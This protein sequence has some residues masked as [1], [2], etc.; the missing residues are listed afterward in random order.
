MEADRAE[1][2]GTRAPP[3]INIADDGDSPSPDAAGG[4]DPA[5]SL[6]SKR[7][8]SATSKVWDDFDALYEVKNGKRVRT[9]AKCK[10]FS[11]LYSGKSA[12][13][14]GH[15]HRHLPKCPT[16]LQQSR[17]A[18]SLYALV[19]LMLLRSIF[20]LLIILALPLCQGK[21]PLEILLS[22]LMSV[23]VSLWPFFNL[24]HLL[25]LPLTPGL[26]MLRK[27]TLVWLLIML[28]LIGN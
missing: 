21:P 12:S 14:T 24:L 13:C 25:L 7:I 6:G 19:S 27:I 9:G 8:R 11:K 1:L 16:L 28:M 22:T 20:R 5:E 18:Q 15:L 4:G 26:V 10:H 17:M 2:F 3:P 23:V